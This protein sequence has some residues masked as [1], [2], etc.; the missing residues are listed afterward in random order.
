MCNKDNFGGIHVSIVNKN[1]ALCSISKKELESLNLCAEDFTPAQGPSSLF[2]RF[3]VESLV[4]IVLQDIF[5]NK[6]R[7]GMVVLETASDGA[8]AFTITGTNKRPKDAT[9]FNTEDIHSKETKHHNYVFRCKHIAQLIDLCSILYP[10]Y[11]GESIAFRD[12]VN[13]YCLMISSADM[14][15][16][17]F[18]KIKYVASEWCDSSSKFAKKNVN[19]IIAVNAIS[20]LS[21]INSVQK[22]YE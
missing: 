2:G 13:N 9:E 6:Y 14:S 4:N 8:I 3:F 22:K 21:G 20:A 7:Y 11:D 10:I 5:H 19:N 1:T 17:V 15:S 16:E 18:S 12:N